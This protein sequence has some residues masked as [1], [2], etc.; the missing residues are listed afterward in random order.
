MKLL[1][2]RVLLFYII[3]VILFTLPSF[4]GGIK[5]EQ[6]A[7]PIKL[8]NRV[9]QP[10]N[11]TLATNGRWR[12][13]IQALEP[14]I[15]NQGKYNYAIP[16]TRMELAEAS[17]VPISNFSA[18]KI[19]EINSSQLNGMNSINLALNVATYDNDRP[20]FYST[21]IKF[22]LIDESNTVT[23]AVYNL[24]FTKDEICSLDFSNQILNL[25]LDKDKILQNGFTQHLQNHLM[26][27]V[28]SNKD[29]KLYIKKQ[30]NSKNNVL[31][32]SVKPLYA[33]NSI[34]LN[35]ANDYTLMKDNSVLLASGKATFNDS[36]QSLDKKLINIDYMVKG[37]DNSFIPAGRQSEDFQY[38]LQTED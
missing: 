1:I 32:Y 14:Q 5:V 26:V 4:A 33:D 30:P 7:S 12:L 35:Q 3:Y 6:F 11:L 2:R 8:A 23:E 17:G 28:K 31:T 15:Y 24:R 29:W 38:I 18:G 25:K 16:I 19:I 9:S 27:Y 20:G 36:I 10:I 13:L 22:S 37:P 21:D 34:N